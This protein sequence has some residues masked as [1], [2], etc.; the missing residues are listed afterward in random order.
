[1]NVFFRWFTENQNDCLR[2]A[3]ENLKFHFFLLERIEERIKK[4][5]ADGKEVT[6]ETLFDINDYTPSHS[7]SVIKTG[8]N[9]FSNHD[10][11][12]IHSIYLSDK[13]ANVFKT[14]SSILNQLSKQERTLIYEK[15][16]NLH[17]Y[18]SLK[19][20]YYPNLR[21]EEVELIIDNI[22]IQVAVMD[23][24][25][26]YTPHEFIDD[27]K[28]RYKSDTDSDV[29]YNLARKIVSHHLEFGN[30]NDEIAKY[31]ALIPTRELNY[32]K[33]IINNP[34]KKV[35]KFAYRHFRT[36]LFVFAFLY[37][38]IDYNEEMFINDLEK[39]G[40]G[41]KSCYDETMVTYQKINN[42]PVR[43]PT[44]RKRKDSKEGDSK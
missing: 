6:T 24:N 43:Y 31:I 9:S 41:W 15:I 38:K 1:M 28:S 34:E 3:S 19:E 42:L 25:N 44:K 13:D 22:L 18:E 30:E 2:I 27:I 37:P 4:L 39:C 17:S 26:P 40:R 32:I 16:H 7:T 29:A 33:A 21:N 35:S 20:N 36:G 23:P 10:S 5:I 14:Y 8:N 11:V 12:L